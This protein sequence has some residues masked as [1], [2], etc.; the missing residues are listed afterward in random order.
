MSH[1]IKQLHLACSNRRPVPWLIVFVLFLAWSDLRAQNTDYWHATSTA[2]WFKATNWTNGVPN[3][4]S[5]VAVGGYYAEVYEYGVPFSV[6][7][8]Y[9][10]A[11][12]EGSPAQ[13]GELTTG[14]VHNHPKINGNVTLADQPNAAYLYTGGKGTIN[15]GGMIT[16]GGALTKQGAGTWIIDEKV[17]APVA[18]SVDAGILKVNQTLTTPNLAV[19]PEAALGGAGLI[20]RNVINHGG[21]GPSGY[22]ILLATGPVKLLAGSNGFVP[23]AGGTFDFLQAGGGLTGSFSQVFEGLTNRLQYLSQSDGSNGCEMGTRSSVPEKGQ[24]LTMLLIGLFGLIAAKF[25]LQ[26][27]HHS[28]KREIGRVASPRR[29]LGFGHF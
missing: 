9:G 1:S 10:K 18:T 28:L 17:G 14:D 24:T 2:D 19:N 23:V 13:V 25:V 7:F 16:N 27:G 12:I 21:T 5:M 4:S 26:G 29:P 11:A 3:L 6:E 15:A 8:G 20:A 22:D